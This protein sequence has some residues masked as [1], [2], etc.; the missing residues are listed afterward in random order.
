MVGYIIEIVKSRAEERQRLDSHLLI[1]IGLLCRGAEK[2]LL[3]T[4]KARAP[5]LLCHVV[6]S[7]KEIEP[8]S[9]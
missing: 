6:F 2:R 4:S 1:Y 7:V 9:L 3:G 5:I 8:L